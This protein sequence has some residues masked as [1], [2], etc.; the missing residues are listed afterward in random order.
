MNKDR[1]ELNEGG[2]YKGLKFIIKNFAFRIFNPTL[3]F[4]P[5]NFKVKRERE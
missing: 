2:R 1:D 4:F 5:V 3:L